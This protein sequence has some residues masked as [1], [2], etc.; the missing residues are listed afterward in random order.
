MT[1]LYHDKG[2][3]GWRLQFYVH[4]VRRMLWLGSVSQANAETV[5][6]HVRQ[7]LQAAD[8]GID[9]PSETRR[10]ISRLGPRMSTRLYHYGLIQASDAKEQ[11]RYTIESWTTEYIDGRTD[12]KKLTKERMKNSARLLKES[13]G[14]TKLIGTV[15]EGD[16]ERF[17]RDLRNKFAASHAGKIIKHCRQFWNAAIKHKHLSE[18]PFSDVSISSKPKARKAYISRDD[19]TR[20]LDMAPDSLWRSIIALARY[21]GLRV[22]SELMKL[23]WTDIDWNGGRLLITSP[24][25]E[26]HEGHASRVIPLFPELRKELQ[27]LYEVVPVGTVWVCTKYRSGNASALRGGMKR[28]I[29]AAGL[30]VWPKMFVNLRAS[31]RV[32]LQREFPNHVCNAWLGHSTVIAEANYLQATDDDFNKAT[33]NEKKTSTPPATPRKQKKVGKPK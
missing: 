19:I 25:T 20:M 13:M 17:N 15:T 22:P 4:G 33:G 7:L 5:A 27:D 12:L 31:C 8:I 14:P 29:K 21:G 10:W 28:I 9:P 16:A 32:D 3:N 6:M 18:N 2:R 24:K 30:T 1:Y 11:K 23:K 26:H